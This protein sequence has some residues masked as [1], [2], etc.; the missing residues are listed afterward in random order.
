MA[1]SLVTVTS[2]SLCE[3][4]GGIDF[5][6][7]QEGRGEGKDVTA[8]GAYTNVVHHHLVQA[9]RAER[10]FDDIC[11]CLRGENW[12]NISMERCR[13]SALIQPAAGAIPF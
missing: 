13:V 10:A 3:I 12:D 9:T 6:P 11:D 7:Q 1:P 2:Y 4:R 8:E 5:T